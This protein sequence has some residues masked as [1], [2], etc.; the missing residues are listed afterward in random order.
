[1][2]EGRDGEMPLAELVQR[3]GQGD[4]QAEDLFVQRFRNG[5]QQLVRRACRP[6]DPQ[7]DDLA[8]DV[9]LIVLQHL[10][11]RQLDKPDA[12]PAFIR[13]TVV[14]VCRAEY[15]KRGRRGDTLPIEAAATASDGED[16]AA[17]LHSAQLT[18]TI[19][20]LLCHLPKLRDRELL[21]RF[22]L[23]EHSKEDVC[24][25]L[26]IDPSHFHRVAYRA[27]ERI[28]EI[29]ESRGLGRPE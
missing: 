19:R 6:R 22:Y 13:S 15:R 1:M 18:D 8:Q 3:I 24:R 9:V 2:G 7:V 4:R 20:D 27:R 28:R 14:L 16:P 10:R 11:A 23:E 12:L 5:I 29:L 17:N 21:Q 25:I 26:G